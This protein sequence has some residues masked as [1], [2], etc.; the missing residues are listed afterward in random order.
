MSAAECC[1]KAEE[2]ELMIKIVSYRPDR[3]RLTEQAR[4]WRAEEAKALKLEQA[5]RAA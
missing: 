2:L 3:D 4:Y 5:R 1:L